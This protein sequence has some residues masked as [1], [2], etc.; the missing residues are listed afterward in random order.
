MAR[1]LQKAHLHESLKAHLGFL[2]S[3][4]DSFHSWL[5]VGHSGLFFIMDFPL[6]VGDVA[7]GLDSI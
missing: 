4:T 1:Q 2:V 6:C 7:E 5:N 3:I